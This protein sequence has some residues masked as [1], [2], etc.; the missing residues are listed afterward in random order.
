MRN[1]RIAR[2]LLVFLM[3]TYTLPA[4]AQHR[5]YFITYNHEM[6]EV[7]NPRD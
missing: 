6:E 3:L 2:T 4:F 7:G 5:P 1:S